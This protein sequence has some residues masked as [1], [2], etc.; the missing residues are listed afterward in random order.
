MTLYASQLLITVSWNYSHVLINDENKRNT[1]CWEEVSLFS[2]FWVWRNRN[3]QGLSLGL[4]GLLLAGGGGS[5][6]LPHVQR[7]LAHFETSLMEFFELSFFWINHL[8]GYASAFISFSIVFLWSSFLTM[9]NRIETQ[10]ASPSLLGGWRKKI[11]W[12]FPGGPVG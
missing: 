8:D 4:Q 5:I 6:S 1:T 9:E 2:M 7:N 11:P 12:T 10:W 3:E